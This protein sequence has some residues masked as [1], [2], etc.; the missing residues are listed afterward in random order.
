MK[1]TTYIAVR[2]SQSFVLPSLATPLLTLPRLG[3]VFFREDR[4]ED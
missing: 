3:Q 2:N 1:P 4:P